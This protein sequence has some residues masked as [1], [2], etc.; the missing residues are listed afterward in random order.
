MKVGF[1]DFRR[2]LALIRRAQA[3]IGDLSGQAGDALAHRAAAAATRRR[4]RAESNSPGELAELHEQIAD[5]LTAR[6]AASRAAAAAADRVSAAGHYAASRDLVGAQRRGSLP[7]MGIADAPNTSPPAKRA[8]RGACRDRA[9]DPK[10]FR[11]TRYFQRPTLEE[12]SWLE[13]ST[14]L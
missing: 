2:E 11:L 4:R 10:S 5:A 3:Q 6:A 1:F 8:S 14:C 9:A 13:C 7:G 12:P